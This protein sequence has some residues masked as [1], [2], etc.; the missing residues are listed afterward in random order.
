MTEA[1]MNKAT[2]QTGTASTDRIYVVS[3]PSGAGKTSLTRTLIQDDR[4]INVA[5]SHTT[6]S[7]RTNETDGIN[8]HFTDLATFKRMIAE[9]EF[10]EWAEVFGHLYGTSKAAALHALQK[11][12]QLV[13]EIDWQGAGQVRHSI[14]GV[15]TIFMLPPSLE[16]LQERLL[17]RGQDDA[18]AVQQRMAA[19]VEEISHCDEFDYWLVNDDF[20]E[21]L[22]QLRRI[23]TNKGE[24]GQAFRQE[25]QRQKLQPLIDT[26]L[27]RPPSLRP[28]L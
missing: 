7:Q 18:P 14:S 9:D 20:A 2:Q 3:G 5:I 26:L 6:R 15:Q 8:Y 16:A 28:S 12:Q 19:A 11:E 4:K 1:S 23:I 27:S 13:L 24:E 17:Q 22:D 10:L 25:R 21:T